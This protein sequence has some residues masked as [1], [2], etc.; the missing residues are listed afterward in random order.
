MLARLR[1]RA[2][3]ANVTSALAL[4]VAL[5]GTSYAAITL[6]S[7]SVG[8][9]QIRTGAVGTSEIRRNGVGASEIN[10]GAVRAGEIKTGAVHGTEIASNSVGLVDMKKDAITTAQVKDGS[11][12]ATDLSDA[13]RASLTNAPLYRAAVNTTGAAV[14]GNATGASRAAAGV[15]TVDFG[16]DVSGC[17]YSA[18]LAAVK[19]GTGTDSPTPGSI[20]VEPGAAT[21]SVV[22]HTYVVPGA[23]PQD[24]PFHLAVSC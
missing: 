9:A 18:T 10:T 23:T 21:T 15:Y 8:A 3:F 14:A 24:E 13:A 1:R 19:N 6:P 22:V 11:L 2:S 12:E 17:F 5:G 16:K 20:T 7:N 4:F